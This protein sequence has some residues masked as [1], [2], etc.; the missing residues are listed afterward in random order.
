MRWTAL[1]FSATLAQETTFRADVT[2]VRVDVQVLDGGKPVTGLGPADFLLFDEGAPQTILRF[3]RDSEPLSVALLID[4]SGSMKK[5]ARQMAATAQSALTFLKPGDRAGVIAFSRGT[6]LL[7]DLSPKFDQVAREIE[8]GVE[9]NSLTSGTAIYQAVLEAA[10]MLEEDKRKNP[11][12]RR[13]VVI[14]TDNASLNYQITQERV[15]RSLLSADAVLNAL[16][17][18]SAERPKAPRP[19]AY[20][21]P[22]FEPTDIFAIAELTGGEAIRVERTDRVFPQL[23]ERLRSRYSLSYK[24]PP[25]P[26]GMFR[27]LRVEL[28]PEAKKK[29]GGA[30]IRARSGYY[31]A[32]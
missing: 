7:S 15:L 27:K 24:P 16:V 4:V 31:T 14:L 13:A 5:Y 2:E 32:S 18:S 9:Q 8:V 10:R 29:H 26:A 28:S 19:G 25:A 3:D 12:G 1:L 11:G 20:R 6:E 17:T 22:D 21:N 23:M 30:T